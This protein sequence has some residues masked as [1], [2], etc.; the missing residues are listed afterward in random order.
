MIT[1]HQQSGIAQGEEEFSRTIF[2]FGACA[3]IKYN[4]IEKI[5]TV[6]VR[7]AGAPKQNGVN[8]WETAFE[9]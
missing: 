3:S 2:V 5:W 1:Q 4:V 9:V 8:S 7:E 6:E